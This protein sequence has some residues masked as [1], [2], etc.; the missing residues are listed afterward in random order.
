ML[1]AAALRLHDLD[2]T[3]LWYD[4]AVS[5]AQSNGTFL[6]L[7]SAVSQDNYPPLHNIVLWLTM[8]VIGDGETALRI[9]S[10]LL[11]VVAVW[12]IYL[13]G[14]QVGGREAGLLAAILL[15]VSPLHIWY[16]TE[17]RMYALL[18]ATGLAFLLCALKV[19]RHQSHFWVF[20][21]TISGTLFLYSHIYA[22][23]GLFS[24]GLVCGALATHDFVRAKRLFLS[25]AFIACLAI[26]ASVVLFLP[27]LAI[28]A[29]RAKAV[30]DE[31]FWIA[32]PDLTFLES[33][34]FSLSG[35]VV[36]F[37]LLLGLAVLGVSFKAFK[38]EQYDEDSDYTQQAVAACIA[39]TIGPPLLA[40]FYSIILQ[41]ILFDRYLIAAWPG[42]I[43]LASVGACQLLPRIASIVLVG[44]AIG[45]TFP[46]LVFTLTQKIRP[47]WREVAHVYQAN[48]LPEDRLILYK[49]FAS[50]ALSYYLRGTGQFEP[51]EDLEMLAELSETTEIG[52][53]WLL[54]VHSNAEE[55]RAALET[56]AAGENKT[57]ARWFGWGESGLT[58]VEP[59]TQKK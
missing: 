2:R 59:A 51:V 55:T 36:L 15:A 33:L 39:Y 57:V 18:A 19:L 43:V 27:W 23:L 21:L 48:R 31:G 25:R 3:S 42:L 53:Y 40:Y 49:A 22:L 13:I 11:G 32:Y 8:P 41:P 46:Q 17:A 34:V 6:E 45:L 24:V 1:A 30:A 56:F 12:L 20:A 38:V 14:K 58:L 4:E 52:R 35:S 50:P 26:L 28:L 7:L 9:P 16:S 29:T 54:L 5:W 44:V 47:E 10:A 37:W